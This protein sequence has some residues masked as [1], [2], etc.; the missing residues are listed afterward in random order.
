MAVN[1]QAIDKGNDAYAVDADGAPLTTDLAGNPRFNG[2]VDLGAYE[3]RAATPVA[4]EAIGAIPDVSAAFGE[5]VKID[6]SQYFS[7]GDWTYSVKTPSGL[8]DALLVEPTVDGSELTLKFLAQALYALDLD[9]SDVELV[10]TAS[11]ADG[12]AFADSNVF[13]VGLT[14]RY[15]A[16]LAAVLTDGTT[17]DAYDEYEWGK[18]KNK[19]YG[20]DEIPT[21]DATATAGPLSVQIWSEDL[22][23][24]QGL[25]LQSNVGFTFVLKLENATLDLNDTYGDE[26]YYAE[27]FNAG[28]SYIFTAE[29]DGYEALGENEYWVS[30]LYN[31]QEKAHGVQ[32]PAMLLASL[33]AI[34]TGEGDVSATLL[35]WS[36]VRD[37]LVYRRFE[38]NDHACEVDRSQVE[39]IGSTATADVV[40]EAFADFFAEE[41]AEDDFWFEFE[42]A[43]GKRR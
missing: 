11:T 25:T 31:Y 9:L 41:D 18:G 3:Y 6:I 4:P 42:K 26:G 16:R 14:D 34:A 36:D 33:P 19:Y 43:L 27:F 28:G 13:S 39:L 10:V 5:T 12:T 22:S 15:S 38:G 8:S 23:A 24:N 17:D 30:V 35:P 20:D 2:T 40:S 7:E 1:S 37:P 32:A 29:K 21:A